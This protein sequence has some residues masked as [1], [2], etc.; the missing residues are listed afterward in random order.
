MLDS[1]LAIRLLS[2][3][4]LAPFA[5]FCVIYGGAPFL[6]M[7]AFAL[8]LSLRE[9]RR[10]AVLSTRPLT[11]LVVG[12]CYI[13]LCFASYA[14]L[15]LGHANGAGLA[16]SLLL[17]VWASDS[18]AYFSG[19][20]IGGPKMAPSISPKK[21]WA[22]LAGG[23]VAS[24]AAL[25]LFALTVGPYL[26]RLFDVNMVVFAGWSAWAIGVVGA[27]ITLA[28][29][30]GDL[31]ISIEKRKVGVKDTGNLIPGHGGILDRIDS[32][33]LASAAFLILV[34]IFGA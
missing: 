16:L 17:C 4:V 22:G 1:T 13:L 27:C 15:R 11:N 20:A 31:L 28:G 19:K 2:A 21:T 8:I 12:L 18:A 9:W 34:K 25:V 10:M 14:E 3:L 29:Q 26:T 30:A 6:G 5:L 23:M 33:M 24:A 32:L 7:V